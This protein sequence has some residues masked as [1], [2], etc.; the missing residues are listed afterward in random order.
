MSGKL[1]GDVLIGRFSNAMLMQNVE[2]QKFLVGLSIQ[3][4]DSSPRFS[5]LIMFRL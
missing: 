1:P 3:F 2:K 4:Q 5:T